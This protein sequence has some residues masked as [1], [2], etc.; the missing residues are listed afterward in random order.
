MK[1]FII[2]TAFLIAATLILFSCN[3][4][5]YNLDTEIIEIGSLE[6]P[7]IDE[8]VNIDTQNATSVQFSWSPAKSGD[9]GLV[10]YS[11][12]FDKVGGDFSEPLFVAPS[13]NNGSATSYTMSAARLNEIADKGGIGQLETGNIIWTVE[14]SSGYN[15]ELFPTSYTVALI[16]PEGLAI[17]PEY[18]YVFG[19]AT[20]AQDLENGIAFKE[21]QSNLPYETIE[22]GTFESITKF[23]S[24]EFYIASSNNSENAVYYYIN[25]EGKIRQGMEPS[26]FEMPE[27]V[28]RIRMDLSKATISYDEISNIEL[29]ILASSV[30]KAELTYVGNH[31]FESVNGYFDFL[32]PGGPEAPSWLGWEEERYKFKFMLNQETPS[33]LGSVHNSDMNASLVPG[34]DA[35]NARPDGGQPDYY[36]NTYFLGPDAEFWQG[37]WKFPS[38]L[39]GVSFTVRMVFDPYADQYYHEL[40]KN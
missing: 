19:S 28:Y 5:E 37:A 20:E 13:N 18:M 27:G 1:K 14:V 8:T 34:F 24:G 36:Y 12:L 38:N 15:T 25:E 30:T 32:V 35:Y 2:Q 7:A 33:Y 26:S 17:F 11:I 4:E 39:N 10:L 9:G 3:E 16:R 21:I 31:T 22:P 6:S 40:I 29:Y 23:T